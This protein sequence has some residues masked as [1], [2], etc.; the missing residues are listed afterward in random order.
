[1]VDDVLG[2]PE[3]LAEKGA[4]ARRRVERH[5]TW[6]EKVRQIGFVYAWVLGQASKPTFGMPFPE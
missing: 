5:F 3:Q 1:M 4:A 6:G 2:K